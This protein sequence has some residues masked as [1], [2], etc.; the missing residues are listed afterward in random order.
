MIIVECRISV[1]DPKTIEIDGWIF[2]ENAFWDYEH[3]G[4]RVK[5]ACGETY[6]FLPNTIGSKESRVL[7]DRLVIAER[8]DSNRLQITIDEDNVQ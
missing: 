8:V 4:C 1:S 6:E 7:C 3:Y 2:T 5:G